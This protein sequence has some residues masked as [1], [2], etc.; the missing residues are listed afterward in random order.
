[1]SQENLDFVLASYEWGNREQRLAADWW[2]ADGEYVNAREDADHG[3]YRGIAAI[4]GLFASWIEAYP[5]VRAHPI[6][7]RENGDQVFVWVRFSGR[8]AASGM[9]L[10]ME[11]AHVITLE[12][13]R[14]RRL[15]EYFDRAEALAAAGLGE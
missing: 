6:E 15:E 2:H 1:M 9:P 4:E 7:A 12:N 3:T 5:D 13:G 10:D 8:G 11:M 14:I